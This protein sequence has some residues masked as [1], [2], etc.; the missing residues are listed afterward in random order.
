M[1]CP[2]CGSQFTQDDE[3][4]LFDLVEAARKVRFSWRVSGGLGSGVL[5]QAITDMDAVL[6]RLCDDHKIGCPE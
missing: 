1:K 3:D 5:E 6:V 4:A 2:T